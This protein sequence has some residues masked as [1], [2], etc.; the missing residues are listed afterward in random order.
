MPEGGLVYWFEEDL[1]KVISTR[2]V[3]C[4]SSHAFDTQL[5]PAVC[6]QKARIRSHAKSHHV[7]TMYKDL[8]ARLLAFQRH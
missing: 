8:G 1:F 3:G 2:S 7:T 6:L 4:A 5:L